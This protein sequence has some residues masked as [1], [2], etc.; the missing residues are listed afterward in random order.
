TRGVVIATPSTFFALLRAIAYVWRQE[1]L[2]ANSQR[3][4][5]MGQQLADRLA[6]MVDHFE[7]VGGALRKAVE[8]YNST[9]SSLEAR[10]LP[11]ARRFRTYGVSTREIPELSQVEVAPRT[12]M[13]SGLA[14]DGDELFPEPDMDLDL[15]ALATGET[16]GQTPATGRRTETSD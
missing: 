1:Q 15:P 6:V 4:N 10:V 12:T 9:V 7:K 13:P 3:I 8:A 11:S 2:A 5:A 16:E 14:A